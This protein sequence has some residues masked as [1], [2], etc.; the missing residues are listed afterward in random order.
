MRL[1]P[2]SG[3]NL[4]ALCFAYI[5]LNRLDEAEAVVKQA[6]ERKLE[7]EGLLS[8]RYEL[9]FLKG[10]TA[11]MAQIVS[12]AMGKPGFEEMALAQEA[13]DRGLV[14]PIEEHARTDASARGFRRPKRRPGNRPATISQ[15]RR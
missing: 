12:A 7:S 1:E 6:E 8:A 10:D 14:R 15:P 3:N 13:E 4:E 5:D 2:N 9:A 11:Q